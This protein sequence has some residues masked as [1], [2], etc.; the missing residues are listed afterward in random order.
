[1]KKV[2]GYILVF[3]GLAAIILSYS[4]VQS[5]LGVALPA[6]LTES[7]LLSIGGLLLVFGALIAFKTGTSKKVTEVPIYHE[8][9]IVGYRRITK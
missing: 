7:T 4:A 1:M 2:M 6:P 3:L 8:K 5:A 9:E